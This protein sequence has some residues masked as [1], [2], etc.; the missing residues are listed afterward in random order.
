MST[1]FDDLKVVILI[2]K[3]KNV[4]VNQK[5]SMMPNYRYYWIKTQLKRLKN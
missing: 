1:G 2:W 4:Q 3:T 5:N